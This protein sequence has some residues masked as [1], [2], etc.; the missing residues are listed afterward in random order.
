M[1]HLHVLQQLPL[2]Q[3]LLEGLG[4]A[5]EA[6]VHALLLA[7]LGLPSGVAYAGLDLASKTTTTPNQDMAHSLAQR[8]P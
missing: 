4:L 8:G 3:H 1:P 5:K 7:I 2:L 6:V